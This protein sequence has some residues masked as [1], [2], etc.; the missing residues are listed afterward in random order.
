M[1]KHRRDGKTFALVTNRDYTA[2][3]RTSIRVATPGVQVERFDAKAKQWST[4]ESKALMRLDIPAG[5]GI[6][7]RW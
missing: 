3:T 4:A 5:D 2:S 7:L 6:L 1:F